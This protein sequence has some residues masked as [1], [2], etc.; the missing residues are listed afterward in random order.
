L[1]GGKETGPGYRRWELSKSSTKKSFET[2]VHVTVMDS[3]TA[4]TIPYGFVLPG[5]GDVAVL[6]IDVLLV[7]VPR[8]F[9]Q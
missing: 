6:S 9:V 2:H 8:S 5:G 1:A 7:T 4:T 3:V